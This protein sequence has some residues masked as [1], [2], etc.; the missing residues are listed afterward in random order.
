MT[1]TAEAALELVRR[2]DGMTAAEVEEVF[3]ALTSGAWE[4]AAGGRVLASWSARGET[5]VELAALVRL[6]RSMAITVD[7]PPSCDV[8]G[9]GGSGLTRFNIS[10]TSAFILAAAGIPVAKHGNLGS[11][12]PNGSFDLLAELDIPFDLPPAA[13][14][15]LQAETGVCFL[16]ARKH[17]PQVGKVVPYRKAAGGR[18]I[19]NLAGPLANPAPLAVQVIG[20]ADPALAEVVI[21]A[22]QELQVARALVV[23]GDPGIDEWSV[24]GATRWWS[25][26]HG[27]IDSGTAPG[28]AAATL[29]YEELPGG[30]APENAAIFRRL[31]AGEEI[32]PLLDMLCA[33]AGLAIDLWHGRSPQ[34]D[35]AGSKL[36]RQLLASG[37]VAT[38]VDRHR[39]LAKE[40]QLLRS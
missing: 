27:C 9:T 1:M 23:N 4:A 34:P 26:D 7:S 3:A 33:N 10:T 14:V 28:A 24:V 37:V 12:R 18:T 15:R 25:L 8:C 36:A 6:L 31:L 32:G 13:L 5:A 40:L 22:L 39:S 29:A 21:G 2:P 19:F 35:G 11:R 38:T 20:V 16:F 17:H 30:D